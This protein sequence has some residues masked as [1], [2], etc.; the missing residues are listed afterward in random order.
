MRVA[1]VNMQRDEDYCLEPWIKYHGDLFG[2]KNLFIIDHGSVS[3]R[4]V[5]TLKYYSDMG[6]NVT[7]LSEQED[8]KRKGEIV[9]AKIHEIEEI[10]HFDFVFPIDCD[11]FL[12]LRDKN[13]NPT[14]NRESIYEYLAQFLQYPGRLEIKENFLYIIK[15]PGFFWSQPYQKVFF[16]GGNCLN[17]DH[18][19]H[20][21]EARS[22]QE[23]KTTTLA[24]AH[25]HFKP[26][27]VQHEMSRQKLRPWVD[28]DDR[29]AVSKYQGPGAHLRQHLLCSEQDY[30]S[31]FKIDHTAIYFEELVNQFHLLNIDPDFSTADLSRWKPMDLSKIGGS[32]KTDK[33]LADSKGKLAAI[34]DVCEKVETIENIALGKPAS[35]SSI[36][37]WSY[38]R[39][40]TND[41]AGGVDGKPDGTM[42]FHTDYED[43]PWWMVDLSGIFGITEIRIFNRIDDKGIAARASDIV[44]E[45]GFSPNELVEI[46]RRISEE[47]FGGVDGNPLTIKLHIPL[48][49]RYIRVRLCVPNYLHLD[50]IEIYGAGCPPGIAQVGEIYHGSFLERRVIDE[51]R[52]L[53]E[54]NLFDH[55]QSVG[56]N[57]EF[58]MVR[59][60]AANEKVHLLQWATIPPEMLLVLL[61]E[62]LER[63]ADPGSIRFDLWGEIEPREYMMRDEIYGMIGHTWIK[64]GSAE[65]LDIEV[66]HTRRLR[67]MRDKF[68]EDLTDGAHIFVY[69]RSAE[70]DLAIIR[71]IGTALSAI[72]PAYL[73]WV[74]YPRNR[75]QAAGGT[76]WIEKNVMCGYIERFAPAERVYEVETRAWIE[77]CRNA[78]VEVAKRD[79]HAEVLRPI[80]QKV[81]ASESV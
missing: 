27:H 25:F 32:E 66:N 44:V 59:R 35:Q 6:V 55:F 53:P 74:T 81:L 80:L 46:F 43:S 29:D 5:E 18:G 68:V 71:D 77:L 70:T 39:N 40:P 62:R 17:L 28:V 69:R 48:L 65:S 37:Q 11:E 16:T 73:L 9:A 19:S 15:N 38:K 49:A 64:N 22:S 1:C 52:R 3:P 45:A 47:P 61:R 41:A 23:S 78:L 72:G 60:A 20:I 2:L 58:G 8:Y 63:F 14:C 24:Y 75:G 26:F 34:N 56:D 51:V 76:D 54:H 42:G 12:F 36:S 33:S 4:T 13:N 67:Y 50:Q 21:G 10:T 30:Y 57:C 7:Y 31:M 79:V